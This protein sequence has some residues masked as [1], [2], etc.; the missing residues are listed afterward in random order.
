M[1]FVCGVEWGT[2]KVRE[3]KTHG[4]GRV[5]NLRSSERVKMKRNEGG[6]RTMARWWWIGES[7]RRTNGY[8][9]GRPWT[10]P[11]EANWTRRKATKAMEGQLI[12]NYYSMWK[13]RKRTSMN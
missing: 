6:L 7:A 10:L 4:T 5:I 8:F 12:R 1:A 2:R 3:A 13:D 11:A 9:G